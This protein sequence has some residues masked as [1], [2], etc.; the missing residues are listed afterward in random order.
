VLKFT[1]IVAIACNGWQKKSAAT[2]LAAVR[3]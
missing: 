2:A 1:L 3:M